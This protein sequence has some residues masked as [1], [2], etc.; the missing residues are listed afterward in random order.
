MWCFGVLTP[1]YRQRMYALLDLYTRPFRAR[2]P[3]ICVDE[4]RK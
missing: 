2:E 3:V 1:Q 4:K